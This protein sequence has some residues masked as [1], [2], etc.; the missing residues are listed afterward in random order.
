[1]NVGA[2]YD[3]AT[4]A[5]LVRKGGIEEDWWKL[6]ALVDDTPGIPHVVARARAI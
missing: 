2:G 3:N 5:T 4:R 6:L 1:L